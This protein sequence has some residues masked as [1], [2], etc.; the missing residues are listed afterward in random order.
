MRM[1]TGWGV[2][3]RSG[4]VLSQRRPLGLGQEGRTAQGSPPTLGGGA[5]CD[6]GHLTDSEPLTPKILLVN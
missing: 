6:Y 1:G 3:N 4:L 2:R 5:V